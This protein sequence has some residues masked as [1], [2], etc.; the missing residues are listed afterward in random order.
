MKARAERLTDPSLKL[1]DGFSACPHSLSF[2]MMIRIYMGNDSL[3][4]GDV[5]AENIEEKKQHGHGC[6][7][8]MI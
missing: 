3:A 6:E 7:F 1:T 2:L 8:V 4:E 5:W